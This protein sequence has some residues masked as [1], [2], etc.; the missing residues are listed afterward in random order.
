MAFITMTDYLGD[1]EITVFP[2]VY[3]KHKEILVENE[4]IVVNIQSQKYGGG[5]W[6]LKDGQ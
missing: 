4:K 6:I 2:E 5:S 1:V 3:E